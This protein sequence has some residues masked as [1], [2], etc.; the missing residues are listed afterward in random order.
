MYTVYCYDDGLMD[1]V[2]CMTGTLEECRAYIAG[3]EL[4]PEEFFI[5]DEDCEVIE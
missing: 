4:M 5:V 1:D 3:I 2:F